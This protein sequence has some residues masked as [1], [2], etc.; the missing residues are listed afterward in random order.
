MAAIQTQFSHVEKNTTANSAKIVSGLMD[1]SAPRV[2]T[3]ID[4]SNSVQTLVP[5]VITS[6][7]A[8]ESRYHVLSFEYFLRLEEA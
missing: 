8:G 6:G 4:T 3:F 1:T 5:P 7:L 2:W